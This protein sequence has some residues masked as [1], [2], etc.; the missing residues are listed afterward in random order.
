VNANASATDSE[1]VGLAVSSGIQ[2]RVKVLSCSSALD[3]GEWKGEI[4]VIKQVSSW[5]EAES[6]E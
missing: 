2:V 4:A 1:K 5:A 3:D 6:N